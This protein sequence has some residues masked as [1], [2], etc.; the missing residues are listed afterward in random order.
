[1]SK[2]FLFL[3]VLMLG[4]AGLHFFMGGPQYPRAFWDQL[5]TPDLRVMSWVLWHAITVVLVGLAGIYLW[6]ARGP[7]RTL[8]VVSALVQLGWA[9]LFLTGGVLW[10]GELLTQ[11]QWV[12]FLGFPLLALLAERSRSGA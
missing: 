10:M 2:P 7:N 5:S 12:L 6:L 11:P 4:T 9:G 8:L 1:M 3:A